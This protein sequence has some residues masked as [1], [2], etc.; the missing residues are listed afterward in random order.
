MDF[1]DYYKSLGVARGAAADEIKSAYRKLA[2]KHH[3][4]V[5][6]DDPGAAQ[7]FSE[8]SEAYEVLSDPDKRAKYDQ[9]GSNWKQGQSFT[10]PPGFGGGFGGA[11]SGGPGSGGFRFTSRPGGGAGAGGA[12]G[13]A[14]G[15]DSGGGGFSSF[16]EQLFGQGMA[17]AGAGSGPGGAGGIDLEDLF[18]GGGG[19]GGFQPRAGGAGRAGPSGRPIPYKEMD[20]TLTLGEA[21]RGASRTL[22]VRGPGGQKEI[23]VKTP[24]GLAPGDKMR[25]AKEGLVLRIA[26][27]GESGFALRGRDVVGK[28]VVRPWQAALGDKVEVASPTG[29]VTLALP[30]GTASG[31]KMRLQ[32]RGLPAR[33]KHPAGDLLVEVHV[34]PEELDD[35]TRGL[36]EQLRDADGG[37]DP[38]E[39]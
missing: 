11:S 20:L 27:S 34:R 24:P 1:K 39:A 5:N 36:Y 12:F 3:P 14:S 29:T 16:F 10:P 31:R 32:G 2:R 6:K 33:G 22:A 21:V 4:D 38:T 18:G 15:G 7:R 9:L 25:L 30:A 8:V 37:A 19:P 28:A 35:R 13:G 17:G 23:E 26:V